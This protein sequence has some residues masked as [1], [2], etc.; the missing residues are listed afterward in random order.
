MID[1]FKDGM[2]TLDFDGYYTTQLYGTA[3]MDGT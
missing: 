1:W 2:V 3:E